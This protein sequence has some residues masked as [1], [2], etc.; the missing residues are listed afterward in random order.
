MNEE[1]EMPLSEEA[2]RRFAAY[3]TE[4]EPSNIASSADSALFDFVGWALA[5]EP[6]ALSE[7]F[8]Y[9]SM[10]SERGFSPNKMTY[11]QTVIVTA[12]PLRL[13]YER[14][15]RGPDTAEHMSL[16]AAVIF[17]R[18]LD[19]AA[20]FY[21]QLLELDTE[22]TTGEAVLLSAAGG[23]HLVLRARELAQH[24]AG[25]LGVQYLIWTAR[26]SE[27]L[28][29]CEQVL[30]AWDAHVSTWSDQDIKVVEGH[31][32][33]RIPILVTYPAGPPAD[34]TTLP[35]RVFAY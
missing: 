2:V 14:A 29:R 23:D 20:E 9:E 27:D 1:F 7:P 33:D 4:T 11:V 5:Q 26:G 10:M 35:R 22:I 13:A 12:Q 6:E 8:A 18:D 30:Q 25:G 32:P 34:T 16:T 19:R 3:V 28:D 21:R 31:D 17:V 15:R 24:V